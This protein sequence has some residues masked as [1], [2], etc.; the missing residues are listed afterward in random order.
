MAFADN[1]N[2]FSLDLSHCAA[3]VKAPNPVQLLRTT[4]RLLGTVIP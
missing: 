4:F 1:K 2:R 3:A